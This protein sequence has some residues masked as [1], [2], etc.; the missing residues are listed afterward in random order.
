MVGALRLPLYHLPGN[1]I[2]AAVGI[3]YVNLQPE[4]ELPSKTRF[5]YFQVSK[6]S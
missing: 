4:Y 1:V 6:M 3:V 5:G 2:S